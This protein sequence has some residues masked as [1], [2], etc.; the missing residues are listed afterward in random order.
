[1]TLSLLPI[2]SCL[3][4]ANLM[5][6]IYAGACW[7]FLQSMCLSV[8]QNH[9]SSISTHFVS[10]GRQQEYFS[11]LFRSWLECSIQ[12]PAPLNVKSTASVAEYIVCSRIYTVLVHLTHW[13]DIHQRH[14]MIDFGTFT[15]FIIHLA[16]SE[17]KKM[18]SVGVIVL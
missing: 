9:A 4:C 15:I 6:P 5:P 17:H 8:F 11:C 14:L 18:K 12:L 1:M 10:S 2:P 3:P 16:E 7:L 13:T